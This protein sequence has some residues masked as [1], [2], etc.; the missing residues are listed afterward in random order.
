MD[1]SGLK[2]HR[3]WLVRMAIILFVALGIGF[4]PSKSVAV[5]EN[6]KAVLTTSIYGIIGGTAMGLIAYPLTGEFKN[7]FLGSSIGLY[8]GI[9]V[10]LYHIYHREDPGNPLNSRSVSWSIK[11]RYLPP[12]P[13]LIAASSPNRKGEAY[14]LNFEIK[15]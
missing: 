4:Y 11:P 15:F 14:S 1:V 13:K 10:G 8:L 2:K 5:S 9:G 3:N 7:V 12:L 6:V